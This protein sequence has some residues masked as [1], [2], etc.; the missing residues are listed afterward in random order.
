MELAMKT[1]ADK[2]VSE[3]SKAVANTLSDRPDRTEPEVQLEDNRA[4][5][6]QR[7]LQEMAKKSKVDNTLYD[8][9]LYDEAQE[10]EDFRV[11]VT[12]REISAIL[13]AGYSFS[14]ENQTFL[15]PGSKGKV[16]EESFVTS[17]VWSRPE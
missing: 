12:A 5:D 6:G 3:K 14:E 17:G 8:N 13:T 16:D 2:A 1:K 15:P 9:A 7:A 11:K 10:N 4:E